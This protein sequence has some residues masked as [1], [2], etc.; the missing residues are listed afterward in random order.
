MIDV[1]TEKLNNNIKILNFMGNPIKHFGFLPN[2]NLLHYH[3]SYECAMRVVQKIESLYHPVYGDKKFIVTISGNYCKITIEGV[4]ISK[5]KIEI[6][7]KSKAITKLAAMNVCFIE[8]IDWYL[9][10]KS[11]IV[12]N[13]TY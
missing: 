2:S 12:R 9:E 8:F 7:A 5:K 3:D 13:G 6:V 10:K 11:N 4:S 1:N